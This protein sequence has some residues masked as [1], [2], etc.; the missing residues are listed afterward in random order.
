[1]LFIA[2]TNAQFELPTIGSIKPAIS[3]S[4]D[5]LIPL[6]NSTITIAANLS[7]VTGGGSSSYV[8]FLNGTRQNE[9]SGSNKNS[10][11]F[12]AGTIGTVYRIN[13]NVT[14]QGGGAL[15]DAAV[16][17][18]SDIDL[19]WNAS[20]EAP[21]GYRSKIFP[22]QNSTIS[23]SALPSI[24]RPGTKTI[25]GSDSLIFNWFINDKLESNKSGTGK[26]D[27]SFRVDGFPG[28]DPRIRLEILT[29][30]KTISLN[31][32][33]TIPVVWPQTFLYLTDNKTALPYGKAL[34]DFV[35]KSSTVKSLDF[36]AENYFFNFPKNQLK[37]NWLV[38]NKE[39]AGGGDKPWSAV[40][41]IPSGITQPF[42]FQIKASAKNPQ[43]DLESAESTVNLEI[44]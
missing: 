6:P 27:L 40:L 43:N 39:I 18:V 42:S 44:K 28:S 34:K 24:Y 9:S 15:S 1:M 3:L 10:F 31:K 5:P 16:F 19:S 12:K 4:S 13:V 37:W 14:T 8:W 25:I 22:T 35:I 2:T 30:D 23:I 38:D 21:A 20:N 32:F 41:N 29:E 17:T 36:T 7:G 26:S 33:I 11:T